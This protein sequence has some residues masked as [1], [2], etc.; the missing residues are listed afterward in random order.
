MSRMLVIHKF[1]CA[2]CNTC[3]IGKTRRHYL[4]KIKEHLKMDKASHICKNLN[5][6]LECKNVCNETCFWAIDS[7]S[8]RFRL[9]VKEVLH[10]S[11]LKPDLNKQVNHVGITISV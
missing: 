9:K 8:S 6:N 10:N 11:W 7:D 1:I 4:T 2:G 3:Y 5:N